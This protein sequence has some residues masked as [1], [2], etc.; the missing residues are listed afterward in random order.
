MIFGHDLDD[1][2]PQDML[3]RLSACAGV[4]P[5]R[6]KISAKRHQP[7][8]FLGRR[9]RDGALTRGPALVAD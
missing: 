7:G 6:L 9:R 1:R 2:R 8:A 5:Q 4:M 3:A